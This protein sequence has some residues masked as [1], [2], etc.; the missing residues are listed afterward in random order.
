[1]TLFEVIEHVDDPIGLLWA[2]YR[3]LRPGGVLVI[4][5]GNTDSWTR[6]MLQQR[7]DFFDLRQ[8]GGHI[9][10]FCPRSMEALATRTGFQIRKVNT[11]SV[12]VCEKGELP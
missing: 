11:S 1:M 4:G 12:K 5:T 10:F 9:S 8:H 7:W 3:V 2:C 6:S